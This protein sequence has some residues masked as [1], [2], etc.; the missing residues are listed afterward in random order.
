MND[1]TVTS[2]KGTVAKLLS[3][4][5]CRDEEDG[6]CT[7]K[8]NGEPRRVKTSAIGSWECDD[9][10]VGKTVNLGCGGCG[11]VLEVNNADI[12][13][14]VRVGNIDGHPESVICGW[15]GVLE[16]I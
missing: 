2:K 15:F 7:V 10:F 8:L 1:I 3:H 12:D 16:I 5:P 9:I 13:I 4:E 11:T 14:A 6:K